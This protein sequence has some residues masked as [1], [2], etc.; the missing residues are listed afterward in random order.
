MLKIIVN[1][2]L[3]LVMDLYKISKTNRRV[4]LP[5]RNVVR[6]KS[7]QFQQLVSISSTKKVE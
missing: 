4:F 5:V 3:I 6:N 2:N 1:N 7:R